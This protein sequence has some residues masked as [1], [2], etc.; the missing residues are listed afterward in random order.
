MLNPKESSQK[1]KNRKTK[2]V[3]GHFETQVYKL[4]KNSENVDFFSH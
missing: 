4:P 3:V 2:F 1:K